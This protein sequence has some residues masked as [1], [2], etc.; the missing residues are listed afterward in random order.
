MK[1]DQPR[2]IYLKDYTPP[3]FLITETEL[4]VALHPSETRVVARL[5]MQPNPDAKGKSR[6]LKLDGELLKLVRVSVDGAEVPPSGYTLTDK[7]LTIKEAPA[8]AIQ[9]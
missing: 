3:P 6:A 9:A 4:D 5:S 7:D 8:Q 1:T 2:A